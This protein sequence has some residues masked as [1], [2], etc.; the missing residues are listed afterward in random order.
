MEKRTNTFMI[1]YRGTPFDQHAMDAKT[2]GE[3]LSGLSKAI[4]EANKAL[5]GEQSP[6]PSIKVKDEFPEG[7]FGV[8]FI[9]TDYEQL[10]NVLEYLGF[11]VSGVAAVTGTVIGLLQTI[12]GQSF[13][14]DINQQK[15]GAHRA[16]LQ[17]KDGRTIDCDEE[18]AKLIGMPSVQQG[19]SNLIYAPLEQEG[20]EAF[21]VHES[22]RSGKA[23]ISIE[24]DEAPAFKYKRKLIED[25]K[26]TVP[27]EARA[28]F[29]YAGKYKET[30]WKARIDGA[31][32]SVK[33]TDKE[34]LDAVKGGNVNAFQNLF[35]VEVLKTTNKRF[36]RPENVSYEIT[37][38]YYYRT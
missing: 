13:T 9:V 24:H 26:H 7:S 11:I 17:T 33:I 19:L 30:G 34:F 16:Q 8:E 21:E 18:V 1:Y 37:K 31:E 29:T 22:V 10:K 15:E 4:I 28:E 6:V 3:A 20:A 12:N 25:F 5:N 2:L 23:V 27:L 36:G 14:I 35:K 32:H 38:V